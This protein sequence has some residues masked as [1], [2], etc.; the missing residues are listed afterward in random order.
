[1]INF[2]F[3]VVVIKFQDFFGFFDSLEKIPI[4]GIFDSW[5]I[6]KETKWFL[7]AFRIFWMKTKKKE[8]SRSDLLILSL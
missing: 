2:A 3:F 8:F 5:L 1:M 6:A 4:P 7:I